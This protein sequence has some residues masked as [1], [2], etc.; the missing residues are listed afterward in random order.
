MKEISK[1]A[2]NKKT[3]ARGLRSILETILLSTMFHL[4]SQDNVQ[5]VI[6]DQSVVKGLSKPI[7]VHSKKETKSDK[8]SA[9]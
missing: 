3:G 2:I 4:P 1:K 6:V 7:I 5:E 8:I 9:A